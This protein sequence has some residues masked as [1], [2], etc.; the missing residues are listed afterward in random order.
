MCRTRFCAQ[1]CDSSGTRDVEDSC[2]AFTTKYE[3]LWVILNIG[4]V[5]EPQGLNPS[6]NCRWAGLD[7]AGAPEVL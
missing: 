2:I 3:L 5:H 1:H 4:D 7:F 6:K